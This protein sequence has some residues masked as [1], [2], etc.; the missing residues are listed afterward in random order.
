MKQKLVRGLDLFLQ[1]VLGMD[2]C[3]I[4]GE[5]IRKEEHSIT[6]GTKNATTGEIGYR[7][8][9]NGVGWGIK[10]SST[11]RRSLHGR[12]RHWSCL[13]LRRCYR[14]HT[15]RF[16]SIALSCW[17]RLRSSLSR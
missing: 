7:R 6:R 2:A 9:M 10:R 17:G 16:R 4:C 14:R 1:G 11:F 12:T 13:R 15:V 3:G 5:P 8:T